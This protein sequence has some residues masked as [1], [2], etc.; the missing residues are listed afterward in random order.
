MP[1]VT[2][3]EADVSKHR[4]RA[5]ASIALIVVG[6]LLLPLAGITVWVRNLVLDSSR[7]VDTM[8]PLSKDPAIREAVAQRVAVTVVDALDVDQR[9]RDALPTRAKFLAA[10][11]AAGAQQLVHGATVKV[12]ESDAFPKI[13]EFANRSA[14]DQIVAALTGRK[15]KAVTTDSGKVVLNLGPL[16]QE[17]ATKLGDLG[18]GVP[19]NVDVSRI[20]T[21][22]VLIASDDLASVQS[23]ARLLDRLAWILPL[24]TLLLY[25][26]AVFVGPRRRVALMRVG[27]GITVAMVV[28]LLGYGFARTTY[29]DGLPPSVESTA[30]AAAIFDTVT[31]FMERGLRALLVLGLL[32]WIA[33]WLAGPS[34]GAR[35]IRS[36]WN[37]LLGRAGEGIGDAVEIGPVSRWTAANAMGLRIALFA[38]L[39]LLLFVWDRPT[40]LVILGLGVLGLVGLGVIQ[41]LA[42]GVP[43]DEPAS[44]A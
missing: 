41:M 43:T 31:R 29:L 4:G 30:A 36:H 6:S 24:L 40:G 9:A 10:P 2:A 7:Y 22:F 16:A 39:T 35:L 21:R 25:A 38:L 5:I 34:R 28:G 37:R 19:K 44:P 42:A 3:T 23:Y 11:I 17:V 15:G 18:I 33:A 12:L 1:D 8:A 13:W 14:H 20:D 32:V 26:A 27:F